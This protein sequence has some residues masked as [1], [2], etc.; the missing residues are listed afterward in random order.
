MRL[1]D[2]FFGDI[3]GYF[4]EVG[5]NKPRARS[6]TWLQEQVGLVSSR[7]L[8]LRSNYAPNGRRGSLKSRLSLT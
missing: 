4:V 6:Q 5:A 2:A 3:K 8:T 7:S 1:V